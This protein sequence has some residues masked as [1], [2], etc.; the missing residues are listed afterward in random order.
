MEAKNGFRDSKSE[1]HPL[2][3][4]LW[5][6][7]EIQR[8]EVQDLFKLKLGIHLSDSETEKLPIFTTSLRIKQAV[9]KLTGH[10]RI[11]W[12]AQLDHQLFHLKPA[13]VSRTLAWRPNGR[14]DIDPPLSHRTGKPIV[15]SAVRFRHTRARQLA[16]KGVPL[17]VL[18]YWLGHTSENTL[19][20]YYND[21]AEDARKLD[22]AMAP[23]LLPLAM[24]FAG[25]LI[26]NQEHASR[27]NDPTSRLE[28]A[29][30]GELKNVGNCG[31]QSFCT[32]TSVP[33]PCYRCRHFE[34]LITAPHQEVL[35]ALRNRQED[36]DQALRIGGAKNLLVPIDLS[37]DILAVQT[38]I[39]RCNA[40]KIELGIA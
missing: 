14:R 9:T 5:N 15:V 22:E 29:K 20:A 13:C 28:F 4:H 31:K 34:P 7:F 39:N 16:R 25:N 32:T 18:S 24:A 21:P 3:E 12:R 27:Y 6:L 36:E 38:C 11:D 33:I 19:Q 30:D 35:E 26:D 2:P 1:H 37:A 10:Y 23:A 17:H 40:R 8:N